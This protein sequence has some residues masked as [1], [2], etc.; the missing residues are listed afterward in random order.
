[1]HKCI[2][3]SITPNYSLYKS[4]QCQLAQSFYAEHID[5][6]FD[7]ESLH[8]PTCTR[9]HSSLVGMRLGTTKTSAH[10]GDKDLLFPAVAYPG[11]VQNDA[12]L[13]SLSDIQG[14]WDKT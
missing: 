10:I 8:V 3:I 5:R 9:D 11:K 14:T 13:H 12:G 6:E 4:Q 2:I 1:M 7:S